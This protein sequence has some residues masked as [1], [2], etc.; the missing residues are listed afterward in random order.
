MLPLQILT[1][2]VQGLADPD[3]RALLFRFLRDH[4]AHVICLQEVHAPE[5][6]SFWT[7]HWGG[8]ASWNH[9]TAILLSP[10]LGG[11]TFDVSHEG[12][13]LAS[14]FR[15]QGQVYKIANI[16]AHADR[17]ARGRFFLRLC[18]A[19]ALFY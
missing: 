12:R 9:Y 16:Y 4:P 3:K 10:S 7:V 11:P 2:N 8:P 17:S 5:D 19:P 13:V 14:T 18:A 1:L 15:F 6:S